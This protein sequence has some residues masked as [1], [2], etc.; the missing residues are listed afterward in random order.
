MSA[1]P[2]PTVRRARRESRIAFPTDLLVTVVFGSENF[3]RWFDDAAA[4]SKDE[5]KR[6]FFLD[7]VVA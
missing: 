4:K 6:G 7:I 5:V 3:K 2:L 1:P